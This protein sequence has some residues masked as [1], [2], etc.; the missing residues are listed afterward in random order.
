MTYWI[1]P[2]IYRLYM[3]TDIIQHVKW[4]WCLR[5]WYTYMH[6]SLWITSLQVKWM[7]LLGR[8][9]SSWLTNTILSINFHESMINYDFSMI[10]YFHI[11]ISSLYSLYNGIMGYI[12]LPMLRNLHLWFLQIPPSSR[13]LAS[14]RRHATFGWLVESVKPPFSQRF[15]VMKLR[16]IH[17][18]VSEN[19]G[20]PKSSILIEISIVNHP[21]WG[22]TIFGNTREQV[23]N[24]DLR[25]NNGFHKPFIRPYC[26][27]G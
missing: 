21:F 4:S 16:K 1:Y 25:A 17:E 11:I 12:L 8:I 5:P 10:S 3:H 26:W 9:T 6:H 13:G 20:T 19:R 14:T 22:T 27:G 7:G 2:C 23:F 24:Q 18:G 15:Q